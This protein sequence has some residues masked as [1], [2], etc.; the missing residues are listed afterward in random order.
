LEEGKE[1]EEYLEIMKQS[2]GDILNMLEVFDKKALRNYCTNINT[3]RE[4]D[5][6]LNRYDSR[7]ESLGIRIEKKLVDINISGDKILFERIVSN[8]IC[9]AI[10]ELDESD[11]KSKKLLVKTF[12]RSS[13]LFVVIKDNGRGIGAKK[14]KDLFRNGY[15]HKDGQHKGLGLYFVRNTVRSKFFGSVSVKSVEGSFTK[16]VL[17]IP[18]Y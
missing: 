7:L 1:D 17:K 6:V 11:K 16:F 2:V 13:L 10:E 5:R 8:L 18:I 4:I 15:T 12:V 9:N 14:R 3:R